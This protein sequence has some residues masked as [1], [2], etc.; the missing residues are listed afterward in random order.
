MVREASAL[1]DGAG[2]V[3]DEPVPLARAVLIDPD[4]I[5]R[6]GLR[7]LLH[8]SGAVRVKGEAADGDAGLA[9]VHRVRPELVIVDPTPR[10]QPSAS[11][12]LVRDLVE[13]SPESQVV[14]FGPPMSEDA[15]VEVVRTGA[16]GIVTKG[17]D[18][19]EL[20]RT[21]RT[22]LR[23]GCSFD[24]DSTSTLVRMMRRPPD[25][26]ED[27]FTEREHEVLEL[28][29]RGLPNRLVGR[30]LFIT[31]ATVKFHLRNIM[32]KV[33]VRR[34]AEVVAVA[35]QRGL[36]GTGSDVVTQA[37]PTQGV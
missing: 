33:G 2:S 17:A 35:L 15:T 11:L 20:L 28:V 16:Q 34:R 7:T 22:T 14:V 12:S 13:A 36:V 1:P 8:E 9:E 19:D 3:C 37:R 21:V 6:F 5:W 29:V 32:D 23:G 18:A 25:V 30:E 10:G 26:V 27:P 4:E 24:P 31:E